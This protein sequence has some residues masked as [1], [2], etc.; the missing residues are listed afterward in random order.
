MDIEVD[1]TVRLDEV[2]LAHAVANFLLD[3]GESSEELRNFVS[4]ILK[5]GGSEAITKLVDA[6]E[7]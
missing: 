7:E 1:A 3:V 4:T 6:I 2:K 5:E